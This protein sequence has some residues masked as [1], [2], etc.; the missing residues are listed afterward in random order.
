M[1]PLTR[2][3]TFLSSGRPPLAPGEI[4]QIGEIRPENVD[5]GGIGPARQLESV[6]LL[7]RYVDAS[8]GT[9]T[10]NGAFALFCGAGRRSGPAAGWTTKRSRSSTRKSVFRNSAGGLAQE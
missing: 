6:L 2:P 1:S 3:S 5:P 9:N 10:R 7:C 8:Q 4:D